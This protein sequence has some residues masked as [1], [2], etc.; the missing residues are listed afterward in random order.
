MAGNRTPQT[1]EKRRRER[2]K[3]Q[4]RQEKQAR[5]LERNAAKRQARQDGTVPPPP[6]PMSAADLEKQP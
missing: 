4:K 2:D 6:E 1:Q 3:Q 5:R